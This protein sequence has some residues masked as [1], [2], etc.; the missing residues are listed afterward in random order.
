MVLDDIIRSP[1]LSG[2]ELRLYMIML[3]YCAKTGPVRTTNINRPALAGLMKM[4]IRGTTKVL[5]RLIALKLIVDDRS[6][7]RH[8]VFTINVSPPNDFCPPDLQGRKWG[9]VID[10]VNDGGGIRTN[11]TRKLNVSRRVVR[12]TGRPIN[13]TDD[14][15]DVVDLEPRTPVHGSPIENLAEI[16]GPTVNPSSGHP[17]PQF[18]VPR[19]PVHGDPELGF[20][21]MYIKRDEERELSKD[22]H[23]SSALVPFK[24]YA[25]T[26]RKAK[27][28]RA[29][30]PPH[31]AASPLS[32]TAIAVGVDH[33]LDAVSEDAMENRMPPTPEQVE[34]ERARRAKSKKRDAPRPNIGDASNTDSEEFQDKPSRRSKK[35][36]KATE[37]EKVV[38][39]L[40][41]DPDTVQEVP[42]DPRSLYLHFWKAVLK[43]WPN[44]ALSRHPD[45]VAVGWCKTLLES[46]SRSQIYEMIRVLLLDY[47]NINRSKIWLAHKG[48]PIPTF[49]LLFANRET[50]STFVGTGVTEPPGIMSSPYAADYAAR[51]SVTGGPTTKPA[52]KTAIEML[53]ELRGAAPTDP[54][55][56]I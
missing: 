30:N 4:S 46:Y 27:T 33:D 37:A 32:A 52:P 50:L 16:G 8:P 38:E 45:K 3:S 7:P 21:P 29:G 17:E 48:T 5:Q 42:D 31:G 44:A 13:S 28:P 47:D 34:E 6:D 10:H 25:A 56:S 51:K 49:R 19:T 15:D 23:E 36:A 39:D 22:S 55:K 40:I 2:E 54:R 9:T 11:Q 14:S 24:T 53:A 1:K 20:S 12:R 18:M 41:A 43:R 26:A 35:P